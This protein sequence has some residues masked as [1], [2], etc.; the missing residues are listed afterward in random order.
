MYLH[1]FS[2]K[3]LCPQVVNEWLVPC[4]SNLWRLSAWV[5]RPCCIFM[6]HK[7]TY[8]FQVYHILLLMRNTQDKGQVPQIAI[9]ISND[10]WASEFRVFKSLGFLW[11]VCFYCLTFSH[12]L[13]FSKG[14]ECFS[15]LLISNGHL[16]L[17][18]VGTPLCSTLHNY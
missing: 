5:V 3:F 12:S 14:F 16:A 13:Y 18:E 9:F 2:F 11:F 6:S 8:M 10:S 7:T 15:G 1:F 17:S 4:I